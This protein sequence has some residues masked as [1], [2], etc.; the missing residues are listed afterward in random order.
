MSQDK[1]LR[2]YL[3]G[4]DQ[5]SLNSIP[6]INDV[7]KINLNNLVLPIPNTNDIA[8][9]RFF[10]L[11]EEF[12]NDCPEYVGVLSAQ[13][14]K[15]YP[16]LIKFKEVLDLEKYLQPDLVFAAS[17]TSLFNEGKWVEWSN[18]YHLTMRPYLE[19]MAAFS[20]ITLENRSTFWANNFICHKNLFLDFI[21][22]FKKTF[23]YMHKK[24][25][26]DFEFKV[27]D[28]SRKPAYLY[29]R[30]SMLFFSNQ[31][32]L[33]IEKIPDSYDWSRVLWIA[34]S[35]SNYGELTNI[36]RDSLKNIGI[37]SDDI[38]HKIIEIPENIKKTIKFQADVW[39]YCIRKKVEHL[40]ETLESM[41]NAGKYDYF[42]STDCDIQYFP[43]K[44]DMWKLLFKYLDT[45]DFDI[46]FQPEDNTNICGGFY[47]IKKQNLP[48]AI[49]FLKDV[50]NG[51]AQAKQK[52]MP[53]A[54]Q[55]IMKKLIHTI[56]F[57]ILPPAACVQGP[58]F[59]PEHKKTY[60]FHHAICAYDK[61]MKLAQLEYIKKLME[62]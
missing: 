33:K 58:N 54:D 28:P 57:C 27:D 52:D 31:C 16:E 26:Y 25:G 60:L 30:V 51:M 50:L 47:I 14:E 61:R 42:I 39:Y 12:F 37:Q 56:N 40:I 62:Y 1:K 48:K 9:N 19:D 36:W 2:L 17:P 20:G 53:F 18:T 45:T 8:E 34:T 23:S 21:N 22:F 5:Q 6:D 10:L 32:D 15:K 49:R 35:A 13:Y 29:E 4:H 11:E 44:N 41:L 55:T 46:Y 3:L 38:K 7:R 43:N 59:V 24:Y